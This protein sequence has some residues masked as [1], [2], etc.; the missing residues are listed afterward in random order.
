MVTSRATCRRLWKTFFK[1]V[2]LTI[3]HSDYVICNGRPCG[4]SSKINWIIEPFQHPTAHI[5]FHGPLC[6]TTADALQNTS[7]DT[8]ENMFS[9]GELSESSANLNHSRISTPIL[10]LVFLTPHLLQW[11]RQ[12]RPCHKY[13]PIPYMPYISVTCQTSN[14]PKITR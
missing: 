12:S 3:K 9:P 14:R 8:E 11:S 1:H 13:I 10:L 5:I 7:F 4:L 6:P 2:N